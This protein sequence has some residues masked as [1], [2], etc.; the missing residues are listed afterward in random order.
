MWGIAAAIDLWV[1]FNLTA[2]IDEVCEITNFLPD[3]SKLAKHF[4]VVGFDN[5]TLLT[6]C[7]Y[8]MQVYNLLNYAL[9]HFQYA[10]MCYIS[11]RHWQV[12]R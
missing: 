9:Y 5:K 12:K 6:L 2:D 11:R 4:N 10:F 7:Q 3:E 8:R 1:F